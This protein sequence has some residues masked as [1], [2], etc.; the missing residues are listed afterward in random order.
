M[1]CRGRRVSRWLVAVDLRIFFEGDF[2]S[3]CYSWVY[4]DG[5]EN[6]AIQKETAVHCSECDFKFVRDKV[7]RC[8]HELQMVPRDM[9]SQFQRAIR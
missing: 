9:Y 5:I 2:R 4:V 8:T 1:S 6:C 3:S 7:D